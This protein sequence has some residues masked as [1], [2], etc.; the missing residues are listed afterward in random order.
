[1]VG[2]YSFQIFRTNIFSAFFISAVRSY[3]FQIPPLPKLYP[4]SPSVS[5]V[6]VHT[7]HFLMEVSE[8]G[9]LAY[10]VRDQRYVSEFIRRKVIVVQTESRP[11]AAIYNVIAVTLHHSRHCDIS[12][13]VA[14]VPAFKVDFTFVLSTLAACSK[15]AVRKLPSLLTLV[16]SNCVCV[17]VCT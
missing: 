9:I 4:S 10:L 2:I 1:V 16:C 3:W 13:S 5:W 15:A 14:Y 8:T 11:A 12:I 6:S 17:C 7:N